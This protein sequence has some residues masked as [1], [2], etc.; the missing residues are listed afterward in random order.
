MV[1]DATFSSSLMRSEVAAIF[2]IAADFSITTSRY[3][4]RGE[5]RYVPMEAGA[6][7]QNISLMAQTLGLGS[8]LIGAFNDESLISALNLENKEPLLIIPVGRK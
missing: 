7:S 1:K 6:S 4:L 5:R 3:S 2:V 8:Y